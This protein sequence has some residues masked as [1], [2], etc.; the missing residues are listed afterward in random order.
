MSGMTSTRKT[1]LVSA[2]EH[3]GPATVEEVR[4]GRKVRLGSLRDAGSLIQRWLREARPS[5]PENSERRR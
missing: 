5:A 4:T 2:H 1:Y 3:D